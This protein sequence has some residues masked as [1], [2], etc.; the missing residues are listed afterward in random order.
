[1][2]EVFIK[3]LSGRKF[4]YFVNNSCCVIDL[5]KII[6]KD[7]GIPL[8]Q[9]ALNFNSRR[10][11]E[12]KLIFQYNIV[13]GSI[14]HLT[15]KLR[16]GGGYDG[17]NSLGMACGGLIKQKIYADRKTDN[18]NEY[19]ESYAEIIINLVS[20]IQSYHSMSA[21]DYIQNNLPWFQLNDANNTTIDKESDIDIDELESV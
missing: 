5:M 16:G 18:V 21:T 20:D 9:Q 15:L 19:T 3:T 17:R 7:Q 8:N 11:D 2:I 4:K 1:M 12:N 14:L 13:D 10:L 6:E